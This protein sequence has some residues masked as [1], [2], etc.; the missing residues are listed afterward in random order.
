MHDEPL[1]DDIALHNLLCNCLDWLFVLCSCACL[2]QGQSQLCYTAEPWN[3]I[4]VFISNIFCCFM[5]CSITYLVIYFYSY[6][7]LLIIFFSLFN[8]SF[9][10]CLYV[11]LL[12]LINMFICIN[13]KLLNIDITHVFTAKQAVRLGRKSVDF[14]GSSQRIQAA[15]RILQAEPISF[16]KHI[17]KHQILVRS[18]IWPIRR[19]LEQQ[20]TGMSV[21]ANYQGKRIKS[22]QVFC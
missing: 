9:R 8:L 6:F 17:P 15:S 2:D 21:S 1:H 14:S 10:F 20:Q 3:I 22:K 13:V 16:D 19:R 11:C 4:P 7:P 12:L 5:D 18:T